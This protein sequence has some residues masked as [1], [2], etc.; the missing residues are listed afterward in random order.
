MFTLTMNLNPHAG[1]S[2]FNN[3]ALHFKIF[4]ISPLNPSLEVQNTNCTTKLF[5]KKKVKIILEKKKLNRLQ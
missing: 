1:G 2:P 3:S 5:H 4:H